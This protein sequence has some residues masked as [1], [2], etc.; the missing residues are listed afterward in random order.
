MKDL[1]S[2]PWCKTNVSM[3][4]NIFTQKLNQGGY[5]NSINSF[6]AFLLHTHSCI[7]KGGLLMWYTLL[8]SA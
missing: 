7:R 1:P 3:M 8:E 5:I 2:A 4:N 6:N